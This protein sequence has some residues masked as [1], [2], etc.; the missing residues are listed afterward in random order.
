MGADQPAAA[1]PSPPGPLPPGAPQV[2]AALPATAST[3]PGLLV[4]AR[5]D[6]TLRRLY[7]RVYRGQNAPPFDAVAA[8]NPLELHT[9]DVV[10][11]PAPA[12]GWR[13]APP[14]K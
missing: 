9:G 1:E 6:D 11:F 14:E 4:I 10:V 7:A 2:A 5:G 3:G 12:G 8:I 13:K